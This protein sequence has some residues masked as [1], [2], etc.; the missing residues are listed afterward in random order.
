MYPEDPDNMGYMPLDKIFEAADQL[1]EI[2]NKQFKAKEYKTSE[3]KYKKALSF[4]TK[5]GSTL[6]FIYFR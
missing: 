3:G 1:K 4:L 2:G 5:L 6:L